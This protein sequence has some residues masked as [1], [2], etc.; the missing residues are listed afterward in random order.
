[1]FIVR[2]TEAAECG[3]ACLAMVA[4]HH[5][6]RFDLSGLRQRF[7]VSLKGATLKDLMR[8]ADELSF[9]TRALRLEL[10]RLKDLALPAILHWDLNHFVVLAAVRGGRAHI[11]DPARGELRLPLAEVS[12]HFTGVALDRPFVEAYGGRFPV[13]AGMT[14][15]AD[16]VQEKRR[17]WR[18]LF[19]P[20][21]AAS[22]E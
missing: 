18:V 17:L 2:Q 13:Q 12:K 9:G 5:G 11:L 19:Y 3:L 16:I 8:M 7:S 20:L 14:L 6:A 4:N 15:K 10:D 22:R 21:L 1:M